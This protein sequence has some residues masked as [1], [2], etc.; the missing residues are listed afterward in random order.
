MKQRSSLFTIF[1]NLVLLGALTL[2]G[3]TP[4]SADDG[5]GSIWD[6]VINENGEIQYENLIDQGVQTES[7]EWM[8]SI[9][10]LGNTIGGQAEYHVYETSD[11]TVVQ[12]PTASTLFFMAL[13][14]AESGIGDASASHFT[15][16]GTLLS[17][18]GIVSAML[19]GANVD[20]SNTEYVSSEQ[21]AE[22]L[23]AGE[24]NIWSLGAGDLYNLMKGLGEAS[25]GDFSNGEFNL[26]TAMLLYTPDNIP[27]ELLALLPE[28]VLPPEVEPPLP[29]TCP[30]GFATPGAISRSGVLVA[31]NFPLVVGQD[32]DKRGV[33]LSFSAS[34]APT[35]WTYFVEVPVIEEGCHNLGDRPSGD[36][37]CTRPNGLP[38]ISY[39]EIVDWVCEQRTRTYPE[40][41]PVAYG[42]ITLTKESQNWIVNTLGIRYP[43][44]FIHNGS[45]RFPSSAGSS[46]WNFERQ[47][48]QV[49]DP[50]EW[51]INVGG[52][53]SGTPVSAPRNFGGEAGFFDVYLKETAIVK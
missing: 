46:T 37:D 35:I 14:P 13:N 41:I 10:V 28:V 7:V 17:M 22:A 19:N 25:I 49:Q 38:G 4:A 47:H 40:T 27:P 2:G 36:A 9:N 20:I 29:P 34:V 48:V 5:D 53:T 31:P 15:G 30:A 39:E 51:D 3:A 26:Y 16:A 32:P 12:L 43:G 52:R 18:P 45:F 8:P 50:G 42:S 6:G 21:Y 1:V 24:T 33:D 44:A 23:L 11:G